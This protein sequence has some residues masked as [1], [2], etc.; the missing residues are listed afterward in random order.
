MSSPP[1]HVQRV[2]RGRVSRSRVEF[3]LFLSSFS[4]TWTSPVNPSSGWYC[5]ATAAGLEN[6]SFVSLISDWPLSTPGAI[7]PQVP[8]FSMACFDE[9]KK[10]KRK[11][12]LRKRKRASS[13]SSLRFFLKSRAPISARWAYHGALRSPFFPFLSGHIDALRRA[14]SLSR[15]AE[16]EGGGKK[17]KSEGESFA[18]FPRSSLLQR[19]E[20]L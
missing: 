12:R 17:E 2:S 4:F 14:L 18:L 19:R 15:V 16:R 13:L 6:S 20:R 8:H 10:E 7:W 9:K 5:A 3:F 1:L 11:K